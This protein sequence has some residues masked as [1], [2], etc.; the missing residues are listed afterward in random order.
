MDML[1]ED[2]EKLDKTEIKKLRVS[3]TGK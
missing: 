3:V 1:T 2:V